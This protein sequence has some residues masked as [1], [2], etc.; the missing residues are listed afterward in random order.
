MPGV[1]YTYVFHIHGS[2]TNSPSI[3]ECARYYCDIIRHGGL[4]QKGL[5][6]TEVTSFHHK[7]AGYDISWYHYV[8]LSSKKL[9]KSTLLIKKFFFLK[10]DEQSSIF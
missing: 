4:Y 10:M 2:Q 9:I 3:R 7:S 5:W 1:L 6:D 8:I